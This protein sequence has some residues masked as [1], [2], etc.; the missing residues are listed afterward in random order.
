M[1]PFKPTEQ[2]TLKRY[3]EVPADVL[4][5]AERLVEWAENAVEE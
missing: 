2:Q 3:Y 5:D 1:Q 4:E